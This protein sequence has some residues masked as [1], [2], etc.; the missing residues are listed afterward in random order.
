MTDSYVECGTLYCFYSNGN[1][2]TAIT[3]A[4]EEHGLERSKVQIICKPVKEPEPCKHGLTLASCHYCRGG[5]V[6]QESGGKL[7][8]Y[9]KP[10]RS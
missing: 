8:A 3:E 10:I 9:L 2:D 7:D 5:K 4:L 6:T 1:Y